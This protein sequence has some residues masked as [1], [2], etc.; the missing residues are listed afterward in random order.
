MLEYLS[1]DLMAQSSN[2]SLFNVWFKG[3]ETS[4]REIPNLNSVTEYSNDVIQ[5]EYNKTKN[6]HLNY[7]NIEYYKRID[8]CWI[9]LNKRSSNLLK[10]MNS[11]I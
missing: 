3:D 5:S 8:I 10:I 1:F 2:S 9:N 11:L 6:S 7:D 4:L